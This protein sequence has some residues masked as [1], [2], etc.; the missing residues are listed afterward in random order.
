VQILSE[1]GFL[2]IIGREW[3][4]SVNLRKSKKIFFELT[5][6]IEFFSDAIN[7]ENTIGTKRESFVVSALQK[8]GTIYYPEKWDVLFLHEGQKFTFEIGG[9]N[10]KF[11]QVRDLD[12]AFLIKDDID[13]GIDNQIPIWLFG[14]LY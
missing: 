13:I 2:H 5:N 9:K 6:Y 14:F 1:I 7:T 10:K 8:I 11:S 12:N 4:I 3:K